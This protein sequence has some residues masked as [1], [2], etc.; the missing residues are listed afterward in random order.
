MASFA[1]VVITLVPFN[2]K[3]DKTGA[4]TNIRYAQ[5]HSHSNWTSPRFV[6]TNIPNLIKLVPMG[7]YYA[8]QSSGQARTKISRNEGFQG[9]QPDRFL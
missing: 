4:D 3:P 5:Q 6:K 1:I 2:E 9:R 8:L 7:T